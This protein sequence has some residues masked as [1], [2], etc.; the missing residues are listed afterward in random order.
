MGTW[1][2]R[3]QVKTAHQNGEKKAKSK[4]RQV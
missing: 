3:Q 4:R 1:S 2:K